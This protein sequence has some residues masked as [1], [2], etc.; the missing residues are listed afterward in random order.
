MHHW[1]CQIYY[2]HWIHWIS[3]TFRENSKSPFQE[4]TGTVLWTSVFFACANGMLR[5]IF[6]STHSHF[7]AKSPSLLLSVNKPLVNK[8]QT[9]KITLNSSHHESHWNQPQGDR[10]VYNTNSDAAADTKCLLSSSNEAR[11]Q[12]SFQREKEVNKANIYHSG[13]SAFHKLLI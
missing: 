7:S 11:F 6:R 13:K 10:S 5:F 12:F 4:T 8:R 3:I 1:F 9:I 2:I